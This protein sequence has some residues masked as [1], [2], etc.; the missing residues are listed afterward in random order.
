MK[1]TST[2]KAE[3]K[4]DLGEPEHVT[5]YVHID[6]AFVGGKPDRVLTITSVSSE[7]QEE[8]VKLLYDFILRVTRLLHEEAK[9]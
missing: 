4:V 7:S 5:P 6:V 9:G 1:T 3:V 8:A 2:F